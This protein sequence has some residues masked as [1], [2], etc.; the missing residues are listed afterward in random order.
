M[1]HSITVAQLLVEHLALFQDL[2]MTNG[3]LDLACGSGRNGI[4]LAR[5]QIP[6]TF[7]DN[8]E[9]ALAGVK[10]Q[11]ADAGLAGEIWQ[12]DLEQAGT[13]VLQGKSFDAVV[14][15]NYLH[16]P[17]FPQLKSIIRPGGIICYETFTVAQAQFGRPSNPD[18][19]LSPEELS[20][21]FKDWKVLHKYE[22]ELTNPQRAVAQ[23]IAR[24]PQE[25]SS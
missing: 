19:L 9:V 10:A 20:H 21:I 7:A 22:G 3:V 11:L 4:Y 16:R 15:F 6:V 23:I 24:K 2:T 17:L 13:A 1:S 25:L 8:N 12:V 14:A 5:H 18:F